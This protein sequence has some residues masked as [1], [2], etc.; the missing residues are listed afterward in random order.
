MN[1]NKELLQEY[2]VSTFKG[3]VGAIPFAGTAL[4]E[5][6]FE[7]RSRLKQKRLNN[8]INNL[9]EYLAQYSEED[10]CSEQLNSDKFSDLFEDILLKVSKTHSQ[11]KLKAFK[12]LLGNQIVKAK[13][14]DYAE[15]M[16]N[17]V[18]SLYEK[19]LPLL[20]NLAKKISSQYN[21]LNID[22][23]ELEK[24]HTILDNDIS[25]EQGMYNRYG[26]S[27]RKEI[28]NLRKEQKEI[29]LL[30]E[31]TKDDIEKENEPFLA[32]TFDCTN[33]EFHFLIN[34]LSSKGLL[35]DVGVHHGAN[36]LK[37]VEITDL[38]KDLIDYI[39]E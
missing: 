10:I 18:S 14:I 31:K 6:L 5:L 24:R 7:A 12:Y 37:L 3:V 28:F 4:N 17:I 32:A 39:E 35:I 36:P 34:D 8:F 29:E 20:Y 27:F 25:N 19:Q 30:I 1:K 13:D 2:G 26:E 16:F 21:Q 33:S 15:L 11:T 22:L 38:G 9:S 23:I